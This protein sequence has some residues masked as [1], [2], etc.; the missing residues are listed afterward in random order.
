M[1]YEKMYAYR[2][3]VSM[4]SISITE[5]NYLFTLSIFIKFQMK[6]QCFLVVLK[7]MVEKEPMKSYPF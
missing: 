7:I 6:L 4:M 2:T 5:G 1:D 3:L